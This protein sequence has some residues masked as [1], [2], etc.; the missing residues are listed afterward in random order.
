MAMSF[1]DKKVS[2]DIVEGLPEPRIVKMANGWVSLQ[3]SSHHMDTYQTCKQ[4]MQTLSDLLHS[5]AASSPSW[6]KD[7][8]RVSEAFAKL[9]GHAQGTSEAKVSAA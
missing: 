5:S 7:V 2:F 9:H 6:D 1:P 4:V 8:I 3:A